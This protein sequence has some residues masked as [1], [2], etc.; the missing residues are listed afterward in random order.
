MKTSNNNNA[1]AFNIIWKV[2]IM[3]WL[4]IAG[5]TNQHFTFS[6]FRYENCQSWQDSEAT[7]LALIFLPVVTSSS[8][9]FVVGSSLKG[10]GE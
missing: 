3:N 4:D 1:I 5:V 7:P 6:A 9:V 8:E 2:G 10:G